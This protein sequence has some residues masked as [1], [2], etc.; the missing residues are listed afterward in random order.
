MSDAD[1]LLGTNV[2]ITKWVELAP[3]VFQELKKSKDK[4]IRVTLE[5]IDAD[6]ITAISLVTLLTLASHIKI[7]PIMVDG[8]IYRPTRVEA[9]KFFLNIVPVSFFV[10]LKI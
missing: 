3:I 10:T 6:N 5:K 8:K 9:Q 7:S 4:D 1:K 2:S